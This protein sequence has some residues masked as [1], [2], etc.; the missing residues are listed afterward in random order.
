MFTC[1]SFEL[2]TVRSIIAGLNLRVDFIV[3]FIEFIS[4][5][6]FFNELTY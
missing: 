6:L 2:F 3:V 1:F 4:V 5:K